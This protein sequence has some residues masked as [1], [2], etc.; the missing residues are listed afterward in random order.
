MMEEEYMKY[1]RENAPELYQQCVDS[2]EHQ[3]GWRDKLMNEQAAEIERLKDEKA[4]ALS[5]A[6]KAIKALNKLRSDLDMVE[7]QE[8]ATPQKGQDNETLP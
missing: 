4:E 7:I 1:L 5:A 3:F 2:F 6:G 8:S